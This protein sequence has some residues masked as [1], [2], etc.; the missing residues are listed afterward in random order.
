MQ[1][2]ERLRKTYLYIHVGVGTIPLELFIIVISSLR[3]GLSRIIPNFII[4]Y[5]STGG[6]GGSC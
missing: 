3:L 6:L 5:V 4:V 1:V 2:A